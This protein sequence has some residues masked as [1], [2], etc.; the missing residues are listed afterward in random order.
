MMTALVRALTRG[1]LRLRYRVRV[2]GVAAVAERG[3]RGILF[4]PNHPALIDPVILMSELHRRFRPRPLADQDQIDRPVVRSLARLLRAFPMPDP[5][6]Y[7]QAS[8]ADVEGA[9]ANCI[10]ALRRGENVLIYPAGQTMR[11]RVS[12][13]AGNSAVETILREAPQAR[14]VLVRT[15]GLWGSAF[16]RA[17][18]RIPR[19]GPLAVRVLGV[20]LANGLF[21]GPRRV[22]TLELVEPADIPRRAERAALNRYLEAFYNHEAPPNTY[23]PYTH[24]E[25]GGRRILPEPE[26][27]RAAPRALDEIPVATRDLVMRHLQDV[28]GL[29]RIQPEDHLSRDLGLDSLALVDLAMWVEHEFGYSVGTATGLERVMDLLLAARGEYTATAPVELKPVPA[30]WFEARGP[31]GRVSLPEGDTLLEVLSGSIRQAPAGA[32]LADQAGGVRTYR[33]V[34]MGILVFKPMVEALEGEYIGIMLPASPAA[35]ILYFAVLAAGKIPV[36]VNWT[37]GV[38]NMAHSLDLLGVKHVLTAGALLQKL[39][40]AAGGPDGF[41]ERFM[42]L[43]DVVKGIGRGRKIAAWVRS[44]IGWAAALRPARRQDTAV[45]LF[46]SGSESLP[47]AVPLTHANILANLRDLCRVFEFHQGDRLV[48]MLPP[49]HSFGLVITTVLPLLGGVPV[50]YHPNPTEGALLARLIE[51]YKVT[52]LVGTPTF[53]NGIV[54][55][56][57]AGELDSLRRVISGAEKCPEPLYALVQRQW[58]HAHLVEGYGITECSPVVS[59]NDEQ[60]P[61]AGT[62]GRVL[63]SVEYAVVSVD[64]G[65]RVPPGR[66]GLLLVRGPS[67]FGGYLNYEG[68]SPFVDFEGRPWYR[69]GDLVSEAPDGVLTFAGR[70]KRFVKL[71]GEMI[72]L[73]AIEEVL[74]RNYVRASDEEPVLAVEATPVELNPELVLFTVRDIPREEANRCIRDAGLSALY[75]VRTVVRVEAIPV[76]G[77]GKTDYRALKARLV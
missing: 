54:R 33:D 24:W 44:R 58:P 9:M 42:L 22:V 53:L 28:T 71:G 63:P 65:S 11:R 50:V 41:R 36:M 38:R 4:L 77:T 18:G 27:G 15:T 70:L 57:R 45:V 67:I 66:P 16:S 56:V 74:N 61:Q 13:L 26:S 39:D 64:G 25:R 55:G 40:L 46:T 1:L 8:Q 10:A 49:F 75:T 68:A 17:S 23:V 51:A 60:A 35:G 72:S 59:L 30:A 37:V 7:G 6:V 52:L 5:A 31:G 20:V 14:V 12:D 62:I 21:F 34:V 69:T 3:T 2:T 29:Q 47:K 48:G 19:L 73:P 32:V 43:E 76:L